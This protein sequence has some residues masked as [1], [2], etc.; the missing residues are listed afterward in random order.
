MTQSDAQPE[1]GSQNPSPGAMPPALRIVVLDDDAD[2]LEYIET[3]LANEGHDVAVFSKPEQLYARLDED[4]PDILLLDM[5]MGRV[6]GEDV[7]IQV[8]ERWEK[9]VVVVITGYPSL[10]SMRQTFKQDTFDYLAKPFSIEE[11][12]ATLRQAAE[13]FGLGARPQDRLRMELGRLIR[14][15]RTERSWT[16]KDLSEASGVSVSQLSSIERAAHLPSLESMLAI[17]S[18]LDQRASTWIGSA[19]F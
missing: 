16:L 2:F 10:D 9:L 6:G 18:A 4:L 3:T 17:A 19:G 15:A 1:K 11:L 8:R 5:K 14:M 12:R 7:L 13:R